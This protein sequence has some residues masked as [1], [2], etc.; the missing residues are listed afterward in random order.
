MRPKKRANFADP[1]ITSTL[2]LASVKM[3]TII[4]YHFMKTKHQT[5][6]VP[7]KPTSFWQQTRAMTTLQCSF[8]S[9]YQHTQAVPFRD[10]LLPCASLPFQTQLLHSIPRK[11]SWIIQIIP[12]H[13]RTALEECRALCT[14][15]WA[16][17]C[18]TVFSQMSIIQNGQLRKTSFF[19]HHKWRH[20]TILMPWHK[21]RLRK[22]KNCHSSLKGKFK[23]GKK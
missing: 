11:R 4:N 12:I 13:P 16:Y 15:G 23:I 22:K 7:W 20:N 2:I 21:L 8:V 9:N 18:R 10:L 6:N 14:C 19:C 17:P 3:Q 1:C 5:L